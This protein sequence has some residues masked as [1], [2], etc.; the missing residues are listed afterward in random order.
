MSI[1]LGRELNKLN[2][3]ILELTA[4]VETS[5]HKAVEAVDARNLD[6][7]RE[8][9]E[10]DRV[11]DR[12][13]IDLEE[14]CLKI[15]ALHQPVATD[16]RYVV[17]C[18]K[19][20]ND[21]ERVG[22]LAVNIAE[23]TVA[24]CNI[25]RELIPAD[26]ATM[27]EHSQAMLRQSLEAL[28]SRDAALARQILAEDDAVDEINRLI[29]RKIYKLINKKPKKAQHLIHLLSVSRYLERIADYATN[30]A[31]DVM[32]LV[33]GQIVRHRSEFKPSPPEEDSE[34]WI[35]EPDSEE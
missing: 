30:I 6:L 33:D 17:S 4:I 22:D 1:H 20:N 32:Y 15:L 21:L 5:V 12:M 29:H 3:M 23:R 14:E 11:I 25:P 26:F 10:H 8:V 19:M 35:L 7:A 27:A 31:E 9:I 18:L 13:E 34:R 16:L 2:D 24:I 28:V